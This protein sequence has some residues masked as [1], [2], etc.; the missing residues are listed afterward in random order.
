[1]AFG[2]KTNE[3]P[4]TRCVV[5]NVRMSA[6]KAR[7]VLD[8]IRNKNVREAAEILA[9]TERGA[10]EVIAKALNSAVANAITNDGQVLDELYVSACF[11]DE[12]TTMKRWRPRARGRATRIR[13]RTCHITLIVSRLPDDVLARQRSASAA[14]SAGRRGRTVQDAAEARRRR[15]QRS[16]GDEATTDVSSGDAAAS[17]S[18][19]APAGEPAEDTAMESQAGPY[20][21]SLLPFEDGSGPESHP[22]KG[23]ADS[24]L[25][26]EPGTRYYNQTRAEVYFATAADAEA[27]GFAVPGAANEDNADDADDTSEGDATSSQ[28]GESE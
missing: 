17:E 7:A 11:A 14:R 10:A 22:I 21:G 3:R 24:M 20:E 1:M 12:G 6:W 2:V 13:K 9:F 15:V 28:T 23:N 4:G 16:R 19:E 27:A 25:Y 18:A 5:R 8:L 26:H